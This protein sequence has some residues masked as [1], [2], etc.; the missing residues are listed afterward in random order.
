VK[1]VLIIAG[2]EVQSAGYREFVRKATFRQKITGTVRNL[3]SGNVEIIAEGNEEELKSFLTT[4]NISE[5]PIDVQ[6]FGVTWAEAT[7]EYSKFSIIRGDKD[8]ELFER[9]D[10]AGTLLYRVVENT[11]LSLEKQDQMLDMQ[12]DTVEEIKGLRKDSKSYLEVEFSE[13]KKKLQ[14]IENALN[15]HGIKV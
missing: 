14:S 15:E 1:Q 5:Y 10:V 6:D 4:I 3:E 13:I 12:Q 2:G 9:I 11:T 7:G 8:S